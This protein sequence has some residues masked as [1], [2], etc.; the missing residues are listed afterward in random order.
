M[1]AT[2]TIRFRLLLTF[3]AIILLSG[4]CTSVVLALLGLF[5]WAPGHLDL[6]T[7]KILSVLAVS[8]IFGIF[9]AV[10]AIRWVIRPLQEVI[11]AMQEVS[12]GNFD[13]RVREPLPE[14]TKQTEIGE[15]QRSFNHMAQELG[16]IELFRNDFINNFS[17]EFKTPIVSI[18]GFAR[19]LQLGGLS[20]EQEREYLGIIISESD[21]LSNMATDDLTLSKLENQSIVSNKTTFSLDEQLRRTVLLLEKEW[22]DKN[23]EL[24]LELDTVEYCFDEEML[25][26]VWINLLG[27]AIKFTPDGGTVRVTLTAG[28]Q[29]CTVCIADTGIG[30]SEEVQSRIFEKFY[31]GNPSHSDK[32][33]GIGLTMVA[34]IMKL[35]GGTIEVQ[36]APGQGST[37]TVYLP[38]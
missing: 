2:R 11:L 9:F 34:R 17:H 37:F 33:N 16:S 7:V 31:Q 12:Q 3:F 20:P 26:R 21:R 13:V 29:G 36:S 32:G 27:N 5:D 35:C 24:M 18:R 8:W 6:P 19:Q 1:K 38:K 22:T 23:I 28:A 30:M 4:L 10:F 15:L 25:L 14:Y